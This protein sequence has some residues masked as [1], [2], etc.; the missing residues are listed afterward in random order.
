MVRVESPGSP[1]SAVTTSEP[2]TL[3]RNADFLRYWFSQSVSRGGTEIATLALPLAAI[4]MFDASPNQLGVLNAAAFAPYLVLT[5]WAGVWIDRRRKRMVLVSA[6]LARVLALAV[7]PLLAFAGILEIYHL[8]VVAF[9]MGLCAVLFDISGTA[10][11]PSLIDKDHLLDGNSKLQ[12]TTVVSHSGGPALGGALVQFLGAPVTLLISAVGSLLSVVSLSTIRKPE[13]EPQR[14]AERRHIFAEIG[15]SLRFIAGNKY[16]RFLTMRSG[17][18]NLFFLARNTVLPLFVL[19]VLGLNSAALGAILGVGAI[20]A[21]IGA[22]ISKKLGDRLGPGRAI[23]VGYG[24]SSSVQILLPA[25]M[26]P[27]ALA[28]SML[29][30]MFFIG[31]MAMTVGNTNVAT[32]TQMLIPKRQMGRVVAG[33]RTVTWG[34]MPLGAL[35]GGALGTA[36]G[37]REALIVTATG[38]CL[39]A[40]WIALSPVAKLRTMPEPPED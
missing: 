16:L 24:V 13:A 2:A 20:G 36:I 23:T 26:G 27:P 4:Y 40:I 6:D 15:E 39:S 25:A 35:I 3:W 22:T 9:A 18:N 1:D 11:L 12:A 21:L 7:V 37:I 34:S 38:F 30:T 14:S 31:G 8:Y 29:F 32:L 17:V 5:L 19:D 10:Y 28:L 33:M